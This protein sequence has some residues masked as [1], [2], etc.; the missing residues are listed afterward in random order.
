MFYNLET[1]I[2]IFTAQSSEVFISNLRRIPQTRQWSEP[3][4]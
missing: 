4:H 3:L 2:K 1:K